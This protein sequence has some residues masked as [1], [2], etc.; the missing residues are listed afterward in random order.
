MT[1]NYQAAYATLHVIQQELNKQDISVLPIKRQISLLQAQ[2]DV[3]LEIQALLL[4]NMKTRT[5][6][7]K[8]LTEGF[9]QSEAGFRQIHDWAMDAQATGKVVDGLLKGV[10]LALTLL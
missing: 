9:R 1:Q 5:D 4:Q 7:Y 2:R 6:Q 10:S 8:V 3:Y